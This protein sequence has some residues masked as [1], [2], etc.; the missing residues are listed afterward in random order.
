MI[1]KQFVMNQKNANLGRS[2]FLVP[3]TT[4]NFRQLWKW[5]TL[6]YFQ[7]NDTKTQNYDEENEQ[8]KC[9]TGEQG[10]QQQQKSS[11]LFEK[12]S[13]SAIA[14][15]LPKNAS[16]NVRQ[17]QEAFKKAQLYKKTLQQKEIQQQKQLG[18]T[19]NDGE[20]Q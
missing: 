5:D 7:Q 13:R 16:R 3:T 12:L 11:K 9:L 19:N 8:T 15:T 2:M 1:T 17:V 4:V 6:T 14:R 18:S 10:N 20:S